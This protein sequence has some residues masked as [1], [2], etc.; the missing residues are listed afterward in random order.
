M[1]THLSYL[2]GASIND[3]IDSQFCSVRYT[4]FDN[5][6]AMIYDLGHSALI[7]KRD[8]TTVMVFLGLEIDS[9]ELLVRIPGHRI[10]EL[11]QLISVLV[12][13][14]KI[15]LRELQRLVG[16]LNL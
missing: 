6:T 1:I 11:S 13:R 16:K 3:G 5:V 4:S 14:K 10:L 15:S 7:A 9:S 8:L 12:K 2:H